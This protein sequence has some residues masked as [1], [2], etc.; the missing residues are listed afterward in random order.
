MFSFRVVSLSL[1]LS[2]GIHKAVA[3]FLSGFSPLAF[4]FSKISTKQWSYLTHSWELGCQAP[5]HIHTPMGHASHDFRGLV[6][7][8]TLWFCLGPRGIQFPV[9]HLGEDPISGPLRSY[10]MK[11]CNRQE[12]AYNASPFPVKV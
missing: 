5:G 3:C 2:Q 8:K 1:F 7:P 6:S 12:T 9:C 11:G 10:R 4:S